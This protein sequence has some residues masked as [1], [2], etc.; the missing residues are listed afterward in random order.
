MLLLQGMNGRNWVL[1]RMGD[2]ALRRRRMCNTVVSR[3][4][5]FFQEILPSTCVDL[6]TC[7][8]GCNVRL[9][10]RELIHRIPLFIFVLFVFRSDIMLVER[11]LTLMVVGASGLVLEVL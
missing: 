1:S 2:I 5:L 11:L 6:G 8:I 4:E 7:S 10:R 9:G 3:I